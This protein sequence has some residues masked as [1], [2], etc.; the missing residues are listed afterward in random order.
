MTVVSP[1]QKY[2]GKKIIAI[3]KP[4]RF[5]RIEYFLQDF[6]GAFEAA[7]EV[8]FCDFPENQVRE[9]GVDVTIQDLIHQVEG[10]VLIKEDDASA[11]FLAQRGDAVYLFMSSKDIYKLKNRMKNF[12]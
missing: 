5:S 8:Y 4:D 6:K 10:S 11:E 1:K 7:D 9:E 2:P 12:Q 3:F